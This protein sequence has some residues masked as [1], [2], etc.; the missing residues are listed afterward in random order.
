MEINLRLL[1]L[2]AFFIQIPLLHKVHMLVCM[3]ACVYMCVLIDAVVF[4]CEQL[5]ASPLTL[6]TYMIP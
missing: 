2:I 1:R 4:V 5:P 6:P 3:F